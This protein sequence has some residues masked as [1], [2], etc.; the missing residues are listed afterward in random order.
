MGLIVTCKEFKLYDDAGITLIARIWWDG[1]VVRI[2]TQS[3]VDVAVKPHTRG[4][5]PNG[6]PHREI[7]FNGV[8][9]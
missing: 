3:N 1:T 5:Q 6:N 8:L 2:D 9:T 7:V 4:L